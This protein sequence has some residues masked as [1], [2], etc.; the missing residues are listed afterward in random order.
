MGR[1]RSAEGQLLE[2]ER[3]WGGVSLRRR[4]AVK[5]HADSHVGSTITARPLFI[6]AVT[7]FP[8]QETFR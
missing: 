1:R 6:T 3:K 5:G 7:V 4:L 2:N 8:G